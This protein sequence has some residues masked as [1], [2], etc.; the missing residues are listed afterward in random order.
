VSH[1]NKRPYETVVLV[2]G[3][4]LS[5]WCLL[6]LQRHLRRCG[7]GDARA[8]SYHSVSRDLLENAQALQR[9]L[10][11]LDAPAVH[12][13]GHSLGGLVIRALF[14]QYPQQ[15]PGRIVTLGSPHRG[16]HPARILAGAAVGRAITGRSIAQLVAGVPDRWEPPARD[17]GIIAGDL[18]IG[19]GRLFP[20][21]PKPNDGVVALA[22]TEL[23]GATDRVTV[24]VS[25]T[26]LVF[27]RQAAEQVC[28]FLKHGRF[29]H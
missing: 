3:L 5:G 22:E 27:S 4:W 17:V 10:R 25:H 20:G 1:E 18:S 16:N 2:H 23:V 28:H 21:L 12:L 13:V 6:M 11:E 29:A 26:A 14:H 7:F 8:F 24:H 15:P 19:L 9:Y